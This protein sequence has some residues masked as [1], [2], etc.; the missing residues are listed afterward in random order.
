LAVPRQVLRD[1]I[2][3]LKKHPLLPIIMV[4]SMSHGNVVD[5]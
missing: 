5:V 1:R 4:D 2:D 3:E